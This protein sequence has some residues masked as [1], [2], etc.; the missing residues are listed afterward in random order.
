MESMK[1][2]KVLA[3]GGMLIAALAGEAY[4]SNNVSSLTHELIALRNLVKGL[5]MKVSNGNDITREGLENLNDIIAANSDCLRGIQR[6]QDNSFRIITEVIKAIVEIQQLMV[7]S[8]K[9]IKMSHIGSFIQHPPHPSASFN[10]SYL[11]NNNQFMRTTAPQTERLQ[12]S[13]VISARQPLQVPQ[14][15]QVQM[16]RQ[17]LAALRAEGNNNISSQLDRELPPSTGNNDDDADISRA[18]GSMM[19]RMRQ[20]NP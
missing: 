18:V 1:D 8:G 19:T 4:L 11:G 15:S 14:R 9:E 17:G 16:R 10:D 5:T 3:A 13:R 2:P 20:T 6:D 12:N 7:E